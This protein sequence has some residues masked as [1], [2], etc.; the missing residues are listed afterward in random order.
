MSKPHTVNSESEAC[1]IIELA[2]DELLL[3]TRAFSLIEEVCR[4]EDSS[5]ESV[6]VVETAGLIN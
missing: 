4:G 6:E 5:I 2:T 3:L 1:E